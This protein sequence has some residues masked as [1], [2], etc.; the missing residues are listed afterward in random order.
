M[1]YEDLTRQVAVVAHDEWKRMARMLLLGGHL[2][3]AKAQQYD[4]GMCPFEDL[5][6]HYQ[7]NYLFYA[8]DIVQLC[9]EYVEE[10][11]ECP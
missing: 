10:L 1:S 6:A 11:E 5:D 7:R 9:L 3:L 8:R 2:D 4:R